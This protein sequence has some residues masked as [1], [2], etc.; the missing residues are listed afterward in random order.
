MANSNYE[1]LPIDQENKLFKE[2]FVFDYEIVCVCCEY[3]QHTI[4]L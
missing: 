2:A 1:I 3:T 4:I